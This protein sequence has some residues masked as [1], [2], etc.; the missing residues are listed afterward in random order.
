MLPS[1]TPPR[2]SGQFSYPYMV[3]LGPQITVFMHIEN[4]SW[5]SL[6]HCARWAVCG[7]HATTVLLFGR[8]SG[9]L[10]HGF[11]AKQAC[12]VLWFSKPAFLSNH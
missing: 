4:M 3:K 11:V 7:S 2:Y 1:S 10:L 5:G 6:T 12:L 9:V 8:L